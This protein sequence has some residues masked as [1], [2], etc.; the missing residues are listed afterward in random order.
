MEKI[1]NT[2]YKKALAERNDA[3][4]NIITLITKAM[5]WEEW[6]EWYVNQITEDKDI[7]N[8]DTEELIAYL[9]ELCEVNGDEAPVF[10]EEQIAEWERLQVAY[11]QAN[12]TVQYYAHGCNPFWNYSRE[13]FADMECNAMREGEI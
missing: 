11:K 7:I 12:Y 4:Y 2:E 6:A 3:Y 13:D 9:I 8:D 10:T 1:H 5:P